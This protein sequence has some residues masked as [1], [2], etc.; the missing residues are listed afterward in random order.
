MPLSYKA[1]DYVITIPAEEYVRSFRDS[2]HFIKFCQECPNYGKVWACPPFS[3]GGLVDLR[4][5]ST[6]RLFAVKITPTESGLPISSA[7]K[8]I[9]P[10]RMRVE[11]KLREMERSTG[12]RAFAFAG[13]CLYC[14]EGSCTRLKGE[15]CRHPELVRPSLEAYGFDLGKTA[16]E[17]FGFPLVWGNDGHLPEYLTLICGLFYNP[18]KKPNEIKKN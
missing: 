17:L 11:E 1:E 4:E 2:G 13:S 16:S 6:V 7:Q 10:E 18:V 3:S 9:L 8:M 14:T 5:Y 12:G 15:K